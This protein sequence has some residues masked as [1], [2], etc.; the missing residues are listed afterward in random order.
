MRNCGVSNLLMRP[1]RDLNRFEEPPI[2]ELQDN[3]AG[4]Q[5]DAQSGAVVQADKRNEEKSIY[6]A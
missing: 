2:E 5:A 4:A 1:Q 3:A 6:V